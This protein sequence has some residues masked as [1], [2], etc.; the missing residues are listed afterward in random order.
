MSGQHF[1]ML[2]SWIL[3]VSHPYHCK[4][5]FTQNAHLFLK[6]GVK[7]LMLLQVDCCCVGYGE[8]GGFPVRNRL[9]YGG[10]C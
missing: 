8:A 6:T 2:S 9:T 10:R 4:M 1:V 5:P 7:L 3:R